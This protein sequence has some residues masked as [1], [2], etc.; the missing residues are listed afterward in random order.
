MMTEF[1]LQVKSL[2]KIYTNGKSALSGVN[3]NVPNGAFYALLGPNGAGKST[4][5]NILAD[6]V[7]PTAGTARLFG[8]DVF[9]DK[10]WCKRHMGVVPQEIALDPFFTPYEVLK[11]TSGLFGC[12]PDT[13]WIDELLDRLELFAHAHK[14]ARQL[15]GGMRRRLL[16]AQALVHKPPFVILDEPTAGVDVELRRRLWNFMRELNAAGTTI[17]LTTHYLEEAEELCDHVT[18]INEGQ[19]VADRSMW[20]LMH[21][22]AG[23]YLWLRYG[24]GFTM[25]D[26]NAQILADFYPRTSDRGVCLTLRHGEPEE[27]NF[28]E[29]YQAAVSCFGAPVDAGVRQE[30]LEDVFIR[31]T[32][33]NGARS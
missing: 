12:K 11:I 20:E 13:V 22:V 17:L 4:L 8:H 19:V 24:E 32:G 18:I 25:S 3:L 23:R 2:H 10:A 7:R 5:I 27:T 21:D 33:K 31:L 1:A 9:H 15:S 29:A 16:V 6:I 26:E 30:D 28:H 14:N